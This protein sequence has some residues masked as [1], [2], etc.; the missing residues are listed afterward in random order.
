LHPSLNPQSEIRIPQSL[1]PALLRPLA[2]LLTLSLRP[3]GNGFS[4]AGHPNRE[5]AVAEVLPTSF[6]FIFTFDNS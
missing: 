4:A 6:S 3:E 1:R 5:R 2:V